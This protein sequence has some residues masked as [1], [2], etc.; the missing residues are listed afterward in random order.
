MYAILISTIA[1]VIAYF[2]LIV[3]HVSDTES[4]AVQY[5]STLVQAR[6]LY[7]ESCGK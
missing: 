5:K 7:K 4:P 3:N 6:R 2:F 1:A